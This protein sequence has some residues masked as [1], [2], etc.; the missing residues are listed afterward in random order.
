TRDGGPLAAGRHSR[1]ATRRHPGASEP[2]DRSRA[3][4]DP[5][6]RNGSSQDLG[7]AQGQVLSIGSRP[8]PGR[9][10]GRP[11]EGSAS[12]RPNAGRGPPATRSSIAEPHPPAMTRG[13]HGTKYSGTAGSS[14]DEV[15]TRGGGVPS[16][17]QSR[18]WAWS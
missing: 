1:G 5:M 6:A 14:G 4:D 2:D 8:T 17:T 3:N 12:S 15:S 7:W 9:G 11:A 16:A 13:P 18:T 10:R